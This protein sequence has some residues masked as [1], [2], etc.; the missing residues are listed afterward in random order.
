MRPTHGNHDFMGGEATGRARARPP[1]VLGPDATLQVYDQ[2]KAALREVLM[3]VDAGAYRGESLIG[4][5]GLGAYSLLCTDTRLLHV[6]TSN[7]VQSW[8]VRQN[9]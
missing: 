4:Y 7:W 5:V 1:R 6:R 9:A 8:Q 3:R 2:S